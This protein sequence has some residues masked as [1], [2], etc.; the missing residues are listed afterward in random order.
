[1]AA[2]ERAR[3]GAWGAALIAGV[4]LAIA[5][6]PEEFP[7]VYTLYL[8]L[9]ARRLAREQALVRRLAGVETLGSTTVIC[10]D[11]T[12]TLTLGRV[13][14]GAVVV[15]DG[16]RVAGD[17]PSTRAEQEVLAASV[18]ACEP[19]PFDPLDC[20]IVAHARERGIDVDAL[21]AQALVR[22]YEFDPGTNSL[23][24]V[25]RHDDRL[26]VATKGGVEG[27]LEVCA[28]SPEVWRVA[29]DAHSRL[30][31]D[32]MRVIAV[33]AGTLVE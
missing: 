23:T 8:A 12:G 2:V 7:L 11:K 3:G 24:H 31:A 19:E 1:V 14:V 32:G 9:G 17:L 29:E 16:T 20:A 18:L 13:E 6:V 33:A 22:D 10:A 30:A 21:H 15:A 26:L 25:W 5:A 27:V 4:S 28:A